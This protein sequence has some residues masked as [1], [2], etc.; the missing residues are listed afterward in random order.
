MDYF[1]SR[2]KST[3]SSNCFV[4]FSF[5]ILV[6]FN[7]L[8]SVLHF[9]VDFIGQI[10]EISGFRKYAGNT[11]ER[12]D[13]YLLHNRVYV[14]F[15][16]IVAARTHVRDSTLIIIHN[17]KCERDKKSI[18]NAVSNLTYCPNIQYNTIPLVI[19]ICRSGRKITRKITSG[20][21]GGTV[22]DS[23]VNHECSVRGEYASIKLSTRILPAALPANLLHSARF[24]LPS[25]RENGQN[26]FIT[27]AAVILGGNI[28][29]TCE[30]RYS[31]ECTALFCARGACNGPR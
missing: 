10:E 3:I 8:L 5:L 26:S 7:G 22:L 28:H 11:H 15:I 24:F 6:N 23:A 4:L 12:N 30:T 14:L 21:R 19:F 17:D 31:C 9:F 20:E 16:I 2:A 18:G 27:R 29:Q 13:F 25:G 1:P